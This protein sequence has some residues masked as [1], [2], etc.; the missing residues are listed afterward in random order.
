MGLGAC[1]G[2]G[3]RGSAGQFG[4]GEPAPRSVSADPGGLW[5]GSTLTPCAQGPGSAGEGP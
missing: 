5:G 4:R 2:S 3:T 1:L